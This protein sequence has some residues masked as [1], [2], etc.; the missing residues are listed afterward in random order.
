MNF[1]LQNALPVYLFVLVVIKVFLVTNGEEYQNP[2]FAINLVDNDLAKFIQFPQERD[3]QRLETEP[4]GHLKQLGLQRPPTGHIP[5]YLI[6]PSPQQ[7]WKKHV[8][9]YRSEV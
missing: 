7:L 8:E 1:F 5:E 6:S 9:L 4:I 2:S 3:I